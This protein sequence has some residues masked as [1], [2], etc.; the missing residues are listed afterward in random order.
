[1]KLFF[2]KVHVKQPGIIVILS[3]LSWQDKKNQVSEAL[4]ATSQF[5]DKPVLNPTVL[6]FPGLQS[7]LVI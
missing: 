1:M 7:T 4:C 5:R 3:T 6:V 2:F